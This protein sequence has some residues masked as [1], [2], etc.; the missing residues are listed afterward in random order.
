MRVA[1]LC[2]SV[3]IRF[4]FPVLVVLYNFWHIYYVYVLVFDSACC[5]TYARPIKSTDHQEYYD[6][7]LCYSVAALF[8]V[9]VDKGS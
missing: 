2:L 6:R 7:M 9:S 8:A 5:C 4:R 1:V 3:S